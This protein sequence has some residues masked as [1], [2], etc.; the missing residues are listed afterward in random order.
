MRDR[1]P[2]AY[3]RV[4]LRGMPLP[5]ARTTTQSYNEL[6][7]PLAG[8]Y[9]IAREL[10]RGG[11]ATVYL[12]RDIRHERDVAVKVLNSDVAA[13]VGRDRFLREIQL[14]AKLAHRTSSRSTTPAKR[15]VRCTT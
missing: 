9:E 14:A 2:N 5:D 4:P 1:I 13:S 8:R 10:G 15:A 3:F 7:V 11:M 6:T 12:A